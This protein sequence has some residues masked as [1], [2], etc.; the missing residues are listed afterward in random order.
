[1]G[2]SSDSRFVDCGRRETAADSAGFLGESVVTE[3][4]SACCQTGTLAALL[5]YLTDDSPDSSVG[6]CPPWAEPP[7]TRSAAAVAL[8]NRHVLALDELAASSLALKKALGSPHVSVR[9]HTVYL[10]YKLSVSGHHQVTC[11][12]RKAGVFPALVR[13]F[14]APN[15]RVR[16]YATQSCVLMYRRCSAAKAEFVAARGVNFLLAQLTLKSSNAADWLRV[17]KALIALLDSLE[18]QESRLYVDTLWSQVAR[19]HLKAFMHAVRLSELAGPLKQL[20]E[21]LQ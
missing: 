10:V 14:V 15:A 12:L 21:L 11:S 2:C 7:A 18:P 5:K 1:M 8:L 4:F 6:S 16:K 20:C 9:E 3:A 17:V 19:V 13:F